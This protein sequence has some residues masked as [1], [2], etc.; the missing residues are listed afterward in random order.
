MKKL[1]L[2]VLAV[3][4]AVACEDDGDLTGFPIQIHQSYVT[5]GVATV[6]GFINTD[7]M[8]QYD[9][10]FGLKYSSDNDPASNG[11][12][13]D[14]MELLN[15]YEFVAYVDGLQP[16]VQYYIVPYYGKGNLVL[17]GDVVACSQNVLE[18]GVVS[19]WGVVGTQNDW[20][21]TGVPDTPM[22]QTG[23]YFVAYGVVFNNDDNRFKIRSGNAWDENYGAVSDGIYASGGNPV[24]LVSEGCDIYIDSGTYNICFNPDL[25]IVNATLSNSTEE[26]VAW[27]LCGDHNAWGDSPDMPMQKIGNMYVAYG[28]N[29]PNASNYFKVRADNSWERNF[30][31]PQDGVVVAVGSSVGLCPDGLSMYISEGTYDIWFNQQTPAL[32]VTA[33]GV[34]PVL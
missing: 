1:L 4:M 32:Y 22:Y 12:S 27:G 30:G 28:V 16:D 20:G 25:M 24:E 6:Y 13:V 31:T 29:F 7:L 18:D 33:P 2:I 8:Q 23:N 5:D 34:A 17:Y 3:V 10:H 26:T 15:E 11:K 21:N 14:R 9:Y 19:K